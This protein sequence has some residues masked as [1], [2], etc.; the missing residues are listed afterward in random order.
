MDD[1]TDFE[2][3]FLI[4]FIILSNFVGSDD[5]DWVIVFDGMSFFGKEAFF[6]VLI[7]FEPDVAMV[8]V[9]L[10][11]GIFPVSFSREEFN[12]ENFSKVGEIFSDFFFAVIIGNFV[13]ID[14]MIGEAFLEWDCLTC[15]FDVG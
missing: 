8:G 14:L 2:E 4:S 1:W 10:F 6:C 12:I 15:H 13:D 11:F 9:G 3:E 7:L 5:T